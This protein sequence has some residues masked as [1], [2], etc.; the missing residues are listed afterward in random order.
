MNN[1]LLKEKSSLGILVLA[2]GQSRRFGSD[3]LMANMPD[4]R[5]V[6]AHSLEPLLTLAKEY[7]LPLCVI[8]RADNRQL[9]EYL[10]T[11]NI[12]YSIANDAHLG[13][14]HSIAAGVTSNPNWQ[15]WLMA[16]ADMPNVSYVLLASL[17]A[18]IENN[19]NDVVRPLV[20]I[21]N[22]KI[23]AHPVYFPNRY[24]EALKALTGDSGAKKIIKHQLFLT[25]IKSELI[26]ENSMM[27]V[28]TREVL[29]RLHKQKERT[30]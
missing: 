19:K 11:E 16:L 7:Q 21:D 15:G 26:E 6:I 23:P 18:K 8:T 5:P 13:M 17:L 2:A 14:G 10:T 28:D 9:I 12:S 4:G 24:G 27:D 20:S 30:I 25:H 1:P 22:N 29:D 3:K